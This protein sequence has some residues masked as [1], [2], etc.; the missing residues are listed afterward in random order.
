M[1]LMNAAVGL[2]NTTSSGVKIT[3]SAIVWRIGVMVIT[4]VWTFLMSSIVMLGFVIRIMGL[5]CAIM[6][7]VCMSN[8]CVMERM[9]VGMVV[10]KGI[11]PRLLQGE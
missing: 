10:M 3:Y 6:S 1:A 5:F 2:V 11:V 4:S 8:G 7:S 9:I